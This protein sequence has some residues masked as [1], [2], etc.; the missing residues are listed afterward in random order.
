MAAQ[1]QIWLNVIIAKLFAKNP[2]LNFC[3]RQDA[4]GNVLNGIAVHIPQ[5]LSKATVVKNRVSYPASASRRTDGDIV[6][7]LEDYSTNPTH[8]LK[9]EQ[10]EITYDKMASVI[11][12]HGMSL[13]EVVGADAVYQ[14]LRAYTYSGSTATAAAPVVRT[15]GANV[16]AHMPSATGNRKLFTPDDLKKARTAM[17]KANIPITDRYAMLSPDMLDQLMSD[18]DLKK[19]DFGAEADYVNGTIARLYGFNI[20]ERSFVAVYED[21]LLRNPVSIE[22]G[23]ETVFGYNATANDCDAV[24]CWQKD[25]VEWALGN[26]NFFQKENDPEYF[27][28]VYSLS[29]RG[30][31][32]KRRYDGLGI[33]SI[34]QAEGE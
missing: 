15:S 25:Q 32:R 28:D 31:G 34:V 17:G 3:V 16:A 19:R 20:I 6:Y 23:G 22:E 4:N 9:A 14:W 7:L 13:D 26:T 8:I 18:P 11:E 10:Y 21:D 12:E 29:V 5:V 33:V 2:H 24:V 1:A 30:G 27:G